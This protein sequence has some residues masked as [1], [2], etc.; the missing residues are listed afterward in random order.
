MELFGSWQAGMPLSTRLRSVDTA[1]PVIC[2]LTRL[3]K[4]KLEQTVQLVVDSLVERG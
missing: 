2:V 1:P 3:K 4:G